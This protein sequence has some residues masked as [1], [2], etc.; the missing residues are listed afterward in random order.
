MF[1]AYVQGYGKALGN[2][3][4]YDHV[5]EAFGRPRPATGFACNLKSLVSQSA[6]KQIAKLGIFV[7]HSSDP[8]VATEIAALRSQGERVVQGFAGQLVDYSELNCDRALVE[9]N[10]SWIIQKLS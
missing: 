7:A 10:G 8:A 5:G 6:T 3:G 2:G 1:A 9:Q 4:R